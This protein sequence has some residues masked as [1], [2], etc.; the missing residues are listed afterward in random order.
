MVVVLWSVSCALQESSVSQNSKNS[1]ITAHSTGEEEATKRFDFLKK[2]AAG[3][4]N[5]S[6][7]VGLP[8]KANLLPSSTGLRRYPKSEALAVLCQP[9]SPKWRG[10]VA[11]A[12]LLQVMASSS[13]L[14]EM[15]VNTNGCQAA[16]KDWKGHFKA[17][18]FWI[19]GP[20]KEKWRSYAEQMIFLK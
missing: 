14:L 8:K 7:S 3:S 15:G 1:A 6:N 10:C 13:Q 5:F 9:M 2:K 18:N 20:K 12:L 16:W 19:L 11:T 4:W 17:K